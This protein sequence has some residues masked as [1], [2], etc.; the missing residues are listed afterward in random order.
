[1]RHQ[2]D[3]ALIVSA[4]QFF[5]IKNYYKHIIEVL[6]FDALIGNSDRHQENWAFITEHSTLSKSFAEFENE[7]QGEA[8]KEYPKLVRKFFEAF[9]LVKGKLRPE[10]KRFRLLAPSKTRFSPI[11]D[12]GCSFGREL[13]AER[14][15]QMLK[16]SAQLDAYVNKGL[17]EIHWN[18]E[19]VSHF[20]LLENLLK[21]EDFTNMV[22]T[23]IERVMAKFNEAAI[24]EL[25]NSVDVSL[26]ES[27]D[28]YKIPEERNLLMCKLV[29]SRFNRLKALIG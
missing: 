23:T 20:V 5:E 19:K 12:S 27:C 1:M 17:S 15:S 8:I 16:N 7:I 18:K 11:Y 24:N 25:I 3:F 14:V 22:K 13:E 6:V 28:S 29:V 10:I 4:L 26:P 21:E 2:Y 9:Y